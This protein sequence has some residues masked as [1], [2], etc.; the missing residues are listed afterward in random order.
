MRIRRILAPTDLSRAS[1]RGVRYGAELA[2]A[3]K[4]ELVLLFAE[5]V[6]AYVPGEVYG[7]GATA[8]LLDAARREA[9]SGLRRI[10]ARL[11]KS[12]LRCRAFVATG[13]PSRVIAETARRLRADWIVL[14]THG[15]GGMSHLLL[16]SVAERVVRT[17]P[18]PVLTV[19]ASPKAKRGD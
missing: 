17:A 3:F 8:S 10:E 14:A 11:R 18:C 19:R 5:D 15:R 6:T 1:L 13:Q 9:E 2:R 7:A 16:G 12:G 4:A